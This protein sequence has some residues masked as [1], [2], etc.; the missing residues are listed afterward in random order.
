MHKAILFIL[1]ILFILSSHVKSQDSSR[2]CFTSAA[3][4]LFPLKKFASS[5]TT[6]LAFNSGIE[7]K[8][9]QSFYVQ[10]LLDF[11]GVKY[12]QQIKENNS[13]YL[14]QKTTSSIF[15]TG[16]NIGKKFKLEASKKAMISIYAG[17]ARGSQLRG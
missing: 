13:S 1:V 6:S 4:L 9:W 7:Y 10:F 11:N 5:Y 17:S 16:L 8:I 12:N 15:M 3:G 2:L 14:F